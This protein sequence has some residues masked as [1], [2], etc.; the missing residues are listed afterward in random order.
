MHIFNF[1]V[2]IDEHLAFTLA[3]TKNPDPV[4]YA[5]QRPAMSH[6]PFAGTRSDVTLKH[7][8]A[9]MPGNDFAALTLL[10][11]GLIRRAAPNMMLALERCFDDCR[12]QAGLEAQ[13]SHPPEMETG[14]PA[15][16]GNMTVPMSA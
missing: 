6:E 16:S 14:H 7:P 4:Q 3:D 12:T 8:T 9:E 10:S 13:C 1:H 15:H 2:P 11:R 5:A